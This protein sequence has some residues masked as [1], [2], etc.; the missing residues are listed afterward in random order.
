MVIFK[1]CIA[2]DQPIMAVLP[3]EEPVT[4]AALY[5]E[6]ADRYYESLGDER[7]AVNQY[8]RLTDDTQVNRA[9]YE[10]LGT[11]D[12]PSQ[13]TQLH[14]HT[15]NEKSS[16]E[17]LGAKSSLNK[18]EHLNKKEKEI[19]SYLELTDNT[20]YATNVTIAKNDTNTT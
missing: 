1:Y 6:I 15:S 14:D 8:Q 2:R 11:Q 13:Y 12:S 7:Q 10:G 18:Y 19:T 16:Y 20:P 4:H 3:Y 5:D 17:K 9:R